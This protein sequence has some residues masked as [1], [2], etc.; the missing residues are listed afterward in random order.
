MNKEFHLKKIR[1]LLYEG[2]TEEELRDLLF[3]EDEFKPL[4]KELAT[5]A[6]KGTIIRQLL[7]YAEKRVLLDKLL[8]W[9]KKG[10]PTRYKKHQPYDVSAL[11]TSSVTIQRKFYRVNKN[12]VKVP[13]LGQI[14]AGKP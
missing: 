2:F 9:A 12:V 14:A 13:L 10:N 11:S 1:T 7:D 4:H 8:A 3:F 5:S 6:G